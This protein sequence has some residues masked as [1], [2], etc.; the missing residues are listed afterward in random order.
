MSCGLSRR[1]SLRLRWSLFLSSS[2]RIG[3]GRDVCCS[4]GSGTE[5]SVGAG[6]DVSVWTRGYDSVRAGRVVEQRAHG[7]TCDWGGGGA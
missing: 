3:A 7:R 1:L 2:R 6:R 5:V 4:V